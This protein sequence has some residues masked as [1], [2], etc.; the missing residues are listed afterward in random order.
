MVFK[1]RIIRIGNAQGVRIPKKLLDRSGIHGAVEM[2]VENG[3]VIL[4]A[5]PP[6]QGWEEAFASMAAQGDDAL[7]D[8]GRPASAWDDAAWVWP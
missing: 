7:L 5:A 6:R 3:A 1:T 4:T 8:S 2:R